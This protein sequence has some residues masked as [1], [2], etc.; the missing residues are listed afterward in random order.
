MNHEIKAYTKAVKHMEKQIEKAEERYKKD[1]AKAELDYIVVKGNEC[2]TED[3]IHE[4]LECDVITLSEYDKA[5]DK[6]ENQIKEQKEVK[7]EAFYLIE[8]YNLAL[9]TVRTELSFLIIEEKEIEGKDAG[10]I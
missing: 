1:I 2:K 8:A 3:D 4:L 5:M 9:K 6:L 10:S 7:T